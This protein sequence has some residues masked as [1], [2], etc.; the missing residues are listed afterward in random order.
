MPASAPSIE[1]RHTGSVP[2]AHALTVVDLGS[3]V[4]AHALFVARHGIARCIDCDSMLVEADFAADDG[5]VRLSGAVSGD[6]P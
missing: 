2:S 1:D 6:E 3:D 4:C 5:G